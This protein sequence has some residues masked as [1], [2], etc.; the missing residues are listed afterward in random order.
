MFRTLP[1]RLL[2]KNTLLVQCMFPA[3]KNMLSDISSDLAGAP[4]R[5]NVGPQSFPGTLASVKERTREH[6]RWREIS[7]RLWDRLAAAPPL[8]SPFYSILASVA[9]RRPASGLCFNLRRSAQP[10][11][12]AYNLPTSFTTSCGLLGATAYNILFEF[13]SNTT[14]SQ[15][16]CYSKPAF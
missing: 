15:V 7:R 9:G 8:L 3:K 10:I 5:Q 16:V 2:P 13:F 12:T 4:L 1:K 14:V 6:K 11:M